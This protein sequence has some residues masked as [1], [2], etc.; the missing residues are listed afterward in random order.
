[1]K[2]QHLA[3][4]LLICTIWGYNFVASK[5]AVGQFP[6]VFF[7]ALRFCA[8]ALLM[9]PWLKW[10]KGQ[11]GLVLSAG[12][13]MGTLHFG[14][15][16]SGIAAAD[17]VAVVAVV[18][19]LGVPIATL[20]AWAFLGETVRWK[21]G[22][23]IALAFAGTIVITFDPRVFGYKE[24]ILFCLGSVIAVSLGQIQVRRIRSVDTLT[25]QAWVGAISGPS[26][27]VLTFL[28]EDGQLE[29]MATAQWQHWA[30]LVY[31]VIAVSL[32]GHGGAYYLLRRYPV[33]I[34]NPGFTLAPIIGIL[35]G[36]VF[37][38]ERLSERVM[39]GA[40]LA[41]LGVL[42]VTLREAQKA[43]AAGLKP[44][45]PATDKAAGE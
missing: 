35:S 3:L 13:L 15:M 4:L 29:S 10:Q 11:M 22:L 2:P 17:D 9:L 8:L 19:Q 26:L 20:M 36:I 16:F 25:M 23:G 39:I 28:F 33:S 42:I 1:M 14:L 43:D 40:A 6:P 30:M 31:A 38:G 5:I 32:I 21:R 34:V 45:A 44:V 7:T 18:V 12:V 24:A 27:L 37:L 41:I